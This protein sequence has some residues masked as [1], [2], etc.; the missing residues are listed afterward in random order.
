MP[1]VVADSGGSS[2]SSPESAD[3]LTGNRDRY[4]Q[5]KL[6]CWGCARPCDHAVTSS[7]V[8]QFMAVFM[9]GGGDGRAGCDFATVFA[10]LQV[11][12]S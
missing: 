1:T 3:T 9:A 7:V 4:A 10:L 6:C 5:C 11:V 8:P 2:D 12:W